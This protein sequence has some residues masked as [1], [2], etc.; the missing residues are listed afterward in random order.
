MTKT[1]IIKKKIVNVVFTV[2][3]IS[4]KRNGLTI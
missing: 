1:G 2:D 4:I 3:P